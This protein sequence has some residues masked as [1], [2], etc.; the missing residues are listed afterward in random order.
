MSLNI[1]VLKYKAGDRVSLELNYKGKEFLTLNG[2]PY[3]GDNMLVVASYIE[4]KKNFV[5]ILHKGVLFD[6]R[7]H[8]VKTL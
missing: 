2:N 7:E 3:K 8:M 6:I 4:D 5:K 1:E